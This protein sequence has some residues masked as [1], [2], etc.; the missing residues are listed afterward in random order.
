MIITGSKD[1]WYSNASAL[2]IN[3]LEEFEMMDFYPM[4]QKD[5]VLTFSYHFTLYPHPFEFEINETLRAIDFQVIESNHTNFDTIFEDDKWKFKG[6]TY[7]SNEVRIGNLSWEVSKGN[8]IKSYKIISFY[9]ENSGSFEFDNSAKPSN[10]VSIP[11]TIR[12]DSPQRY[13][14]MI[15]FYS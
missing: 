15:Y 13:S 12:V 1:F 4:E 7:N 2:A 10:L 6:L 9:G 5:M 14:V 3:S 8:N 11:K